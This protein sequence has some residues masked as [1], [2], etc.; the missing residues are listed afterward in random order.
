MAHRFINCELHNYIGSES[1]IVNCI[2]FLL[3]HFGEFCDRLAAS[4]RDRCIFT[5]NKRRSRPDGKESKKK[6]T[7]TDCE[8]VQISIGGTSL[9][10]ISCAVTHYLCAPKFFQDG[11]CWSRP[12][13][14]KYVVFLYAAST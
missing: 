7:N 14:L 3:F 9:L 2:G 4:G 5:V 10:Y 12:C 1:F 13:V 8:F 11:I 6:G